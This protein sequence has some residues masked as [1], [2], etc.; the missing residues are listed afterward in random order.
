[1]FLPPEVQITKLFLEYSLKKLYNG[2]F[3]PGSG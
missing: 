2:E 1:M 3:D